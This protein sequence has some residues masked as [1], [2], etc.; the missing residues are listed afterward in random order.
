M[1]VKIVC[2]SACDLPASLL[3]QYDLTVV[4]LEVRLNGH[5]VSALYREP[6]RFWAEVQERGGR[7]RTAAPSPS[8]VAAHLRPL[9]ERGHEV[10]AIT[11]SSRLS[12]VYEAF[13]LAA[14]PFAGRVHVFDS[15]SLSL[16]I[17]LQVLE[18]ARRAQAGESA[19]AILAYLTHLR[20]R[21]RVQAVLDTLDWAER[22]GR[23]AALLP[24]IRRTARVFNVK[25]LLHVVEG[26]VRLLGVRRSWRSAVAAL[27]AHTLSL[28]P[29]HALAI[30]HTRRHREAQALAATLAKPLGL[31]PKDVLVN[32]AGPILAAHVGPGALGTVV[33][34][35]QEVGHATA[36]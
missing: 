14:A 6:E 20:E 23:I 4:P 31:S 27:Q 7:P 34:T 22:G 11:L 36:G 16:G 5:D 15:Q 21:V 2:D 33:I 24:L 12:A 25:V 26:E 35:A 17:G 28:A 3:R 1:R 29:V 19:T 30:P 9:V 10:I 32:E 13:R 8:W 18:A